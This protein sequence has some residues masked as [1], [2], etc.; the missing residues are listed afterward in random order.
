MKNPIQNTALIAAL[1]SIIGKMIYHF[2]L[3]DQPDFDM[4]THFFYLLCFL[5]ALF[6]GL[7]S[8]KIQHLGSKFTDDIKSGLKIASIYSLVISGFTWLYYAK[9]NPEYFANRIA[10]AIK[11]AEDAGI[12]LDEIENVRDTTS[13]IFD[14]FTHSTLTLFGYIAMG[15]FYTIILVMF[16]RYRP[17]AFGI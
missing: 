7:R 11:A 6:I 5:A 8:W 10:K 13:F 3:L 12:T 17:K 14:A 16:F 9:L 1:V 4:Y 15:F 2:F